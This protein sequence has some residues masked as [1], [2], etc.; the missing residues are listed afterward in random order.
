MKYFVLWVFQN[1]KGVKKVDNIGRKH[2]YEFYE[3]LQM[4]GMADKTIYN[5]FLAIEKIWIESEKKGVPPKPR[6]IEM[7]TESN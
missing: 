4:G 5:Y 6:L 7:N 3:H 2:V 1:K